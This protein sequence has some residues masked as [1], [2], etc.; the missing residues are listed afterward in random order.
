LIRGCGL[1]R[2]KV[3]V[4]MMKIEGKLRKKEGFLRSCA[5]GLERGDWFLGWLK[6][7]E[8]FSENFVK[9]KIL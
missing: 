5:Y 2:V 8:R 9:I 6:R 4:K 1:K 7:K 3:R